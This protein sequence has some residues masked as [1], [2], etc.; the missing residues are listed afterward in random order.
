MPGFLRAGKRSGGLPARL[1]RSSHRPV[2]G[3][4]SISDQYIK[5]SL[6][7]KTLGLKESELARLVA[8]LRDLQDPS[9]DAVAE[10]IG[11][12]KLAGVRVDLRL[13]TAETGALVSAITR[14]ITRAP[15]PQGRFNQLLSLARAAE[16]AWSK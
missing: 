16:E 6:G 14:V 12:L 11:A 8:S 2:L 15:G 7:R 4:G 1:G 5:V 3:W 10:E 13:N 9:A